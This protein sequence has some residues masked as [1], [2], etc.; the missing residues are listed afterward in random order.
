MG[1]RILTAIEE[2]TQLVKDQRRQVVM[3]HPSNHQEPIPL[4]SLSRP[5]RDLTAS[6]C[7]HQTQ[8]SKGLDSL[9][10]WLVF[11]PRIDLIPVGDAQLIPMPDELP[12]I[13]LSERSRFQLNYC[14]VVLNV[15]PMLDLV[16]PNQYVTHIAENGIDWTTRACLVA[17]VCATGDL[18]QGKSYRDTK[19]SSHGRP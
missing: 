13:K 5:R 2:L 1:G 18:C 8:F 10:G 12:P 9:F 16:T 6:T 7:P 4:S 3:D 17:L 15:N 11:E 14:C 19:Q